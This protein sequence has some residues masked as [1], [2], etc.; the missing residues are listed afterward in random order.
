M[1]VKAVKKDGAATILLQSIAGLSILVLLPF[2]HFTWPSASHTLLLLAGACIFYAINDRM[3]TTVR[4]HLEV[5]TFSILSQISTVFLII[6]GFTFFKDP[7]VLTKVMGGLLIL[8]ANIWLFYKP[9]SH[10]FII[11]KYSWLAIG[12]ALA[13]AV[14]ISIDI[15]ISKSFN[16]PFYISLTLLIPA[17]MIIIGEKLKLT[18]IINEYQTGP[19]KWFLITGLSWGLAI[20]FSLRAFKFGTVSTI[21]PLEAVAVILN[22]FAAYIFLKERDRP[23]QKIFGAILVVLG[24]LLTVH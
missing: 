7:F 10:N 11:S 21:V 9:K 2:F 23:Y 8:A 3:Q 22:V 17:V 6:F 13:F 18:E 1:A 16:L 19:K 5:S 14:A 4:K 15:D 20:F 12:A 24:V